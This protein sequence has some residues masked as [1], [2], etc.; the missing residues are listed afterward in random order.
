MQRVVKGFAFSSKHILMIIEIT[1]Q[2]N[3]SRPMPWTPLLAFGIR[4]Y[5]EKQVVFETF[6]N[7][8]VDPL[9]TGKNTPAPILPYP[10]ETA[11]V[12]LLRNGDT[13]V[14]GHPKHQLG[15]GYS[16]PC[17]APSVRS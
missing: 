14:S 7:L 6:P 3:S 11:W 15:F 1:F 9:H 17:A 2:T 8:A 16:L 12:G 5:V 4:T 10:S 13:T